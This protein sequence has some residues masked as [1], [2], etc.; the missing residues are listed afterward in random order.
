MGRSL[1]CSITGSLGNGAGADNV[2]SD[3]SAAAPTTTSPSS[4]CIDEISGNAL[5]ALKCFTAVLNKSPKD[6][7]ALTYRGWTLALSAQS[8]SNAQQ[9]TELVQGALSD[10]TKAEQIDPSLPDTHVF[11]GIVYLNTQRCDDARAEL[12]KLDALNLPSNSPILQL[13]NSRLRP[14]LANGACPGS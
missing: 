7:M 2:A 3:S 9:A 11:L 14:Q 5:N 12:A 8:T 1:W 4:K 10:L 13:V 6:A